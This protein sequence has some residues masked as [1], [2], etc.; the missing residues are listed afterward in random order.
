MTSVK[1]EKKKPSGLADS[2]SSAPESGENDGFGSGRPFFGPKIFG[3]KSR[4]LKKRLIIDY[5]G[6][7]ALIDR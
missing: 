3:Q 6:R 4:F 1:I 2:E 7:E 5:R